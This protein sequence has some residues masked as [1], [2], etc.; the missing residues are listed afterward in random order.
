MM[1]NPEFRAD[2]ETVKAEIRKGLNLN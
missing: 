2:Y 1:K